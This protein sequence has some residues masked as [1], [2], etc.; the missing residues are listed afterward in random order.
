MRLLGGRAPWLCLSVLPALSAWA[1]RQGLNTLECL[2]TLIT[3]VTGTMLW[4][5]TRSRYGPL[6]DESCQIADT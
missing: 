6:I 5:L 3:L 4:Q 1:V 2:I